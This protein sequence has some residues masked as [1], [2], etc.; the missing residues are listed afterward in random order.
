MGVI[1]NPPAHRCSP[2]A[3]GIYQRLPDNISFCHLQPTILILP[4]SP[5]SHIKCQKC[6]LSTLLVFALPPCIG[7]FSAVDSLS[8]HHGKTAACGAASTLRTPCSRRRQVTL[9]DT[10]AES[11][12]R[13]LSNKMLQRSNKPTTSSG[14]TVA[15]TMALV[16]LG[17]LRFRAALVGRMNHFTRPLMSPR[18]AKRRQL[19]RKKNHTYISV[20]LM[21]CMLSAAK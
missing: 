20:I 4:L 8:R 7:S 18:A 13:L 11:A 14:C 2:V 9:C 10:A 21:C 12:L 5:F 17:I 1:H 16:R 3:I 19:Q 6:V 15:A